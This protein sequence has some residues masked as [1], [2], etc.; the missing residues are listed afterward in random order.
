MIGGILLAAGAA[1]RFGAAKL[2]QRL[3]DGT[4]I[5]LASL[6]NLQAALDHVVVVL[7]PGD[8]AVAGLYSGTG[9][10]TLV[11]PDADLGMGHSLAAGVAHHAQAQGWIIGLADMPGILPQ[12]IRAVACELYERGGIVVPYFRSER[13][14]PV[15]F[16]AAFREELLALQGDSGARAILQAHPQAIHRLAIDDRGVLQDIDTPQDLQRVIDS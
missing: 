3:A 15:G 2:L 4:P 10:R 6:R 13:G 5:G 7:R 9:A 16:G 1:R 12:T 14:H 11:C 8:E